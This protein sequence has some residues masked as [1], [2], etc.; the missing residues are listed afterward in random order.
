MTRPGT[1]IPAEQ[2]LRAILRRLAE[3]GDLDL[4]V[5]SAYLDVRP[6]AT[7]QSPGRR[8]S[9]T[10]LRDRLRAIE[11]TYWPRGDDYDSFTADR[12]RIEAFVEVELDVAAE[13]LA[14]FACSGRGVWEVVQAGV[15]FRDSV[16]AGPRPDVFQLARLVDEHETAVIAVVDSNTARLF[17]SRVG[18]LEEVGGPDE[19]SESFRKRSLGG[20]SQSRYQRHIDKHIADFA[21]AAAAAIEE[22]VTLEGAR[23]VVLAGDEVALTPL[24]DSLSPA[25]R[26]RVAENARI[27]IRAPRDEV[28]EEI[29][30]ILERLEAEEGES[31]ADRIIGLVRAGGLAVVGVGS[32]RR[33]LEIG[34]VDTLAVL[35][36]PGE[37]PERGAGHDARALQ[38]RDDVAAESETSRLDIGMRDEFVRLAALTSAEVQVVDAH[39]ALEHVGGVGALLRYH[40]G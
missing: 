9:L 10:V 16:S 31:I 37:A 28:A 8:A 3:S 24:R 20:W 25:M 11:R 38:D 12:Q 4:P 33:M 7:G 1:T 23:R 27:D 21:K 13:G 32:T 17:V 35:G 15:P 5:L 22:L 36:L 34:A 26:E 30:P 29:R 39:E 40:P 6:E 14:I 2:D 19:G 18:T